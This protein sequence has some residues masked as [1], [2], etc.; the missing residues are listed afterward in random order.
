[1]N[2]NNAPELVKPGPIE[3]AECSVLVTKA[4]ILRQDIY[5]EQDISLADHLLQY[6]WN[7][8]VTDFLE[9]VAGIAHPGIEVP[10]AYGA[11]VFRYKSN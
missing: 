5:D 2:Q 6:E 9:V 10:E 7:P 8:N 1:M 11:L 3:I 4:V